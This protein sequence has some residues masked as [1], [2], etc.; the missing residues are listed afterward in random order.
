MKEHA[1]CFTHI[2]IITLPPPLPARLFVFLPL[3]NNSLK[4]ERGQRHVSPHLSH[5]D[6]GMGDGVG[7]RGRGGN[8]SH[9]YM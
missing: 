3:L 6:E 9:S 5:Q 4:T 7:G 2:I 8:H 1:I